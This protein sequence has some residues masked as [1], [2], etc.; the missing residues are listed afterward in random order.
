MI[1]EFR[2]EETGKIIEEW[3]RV[4]QCPEFLEKDGKKYTR[5]FSAPNVIMEMS[6]PKTVGD[7]A[8]RN[9]REMQKRGTLPKDSGRKRPDLSL[10][11][12]TPAQQKRYILEGKKP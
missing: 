2:N 9:T 6:Q 10:A 7:L 1:F 11:R 12:M 8:E 5:I 3:F 4:G